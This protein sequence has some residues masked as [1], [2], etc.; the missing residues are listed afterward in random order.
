MN[1]SNKAQAPAKIDVLAIIDEV[2]RIVRHD[3]IDGPCTKEL[4]EAR[5]AIVELI[6]ASTAKPKD[7]VFP[8]IQAALLTTFG[9]SAR[10]IVDFD[11]FPLG[12]GGNWGD[13]KVGPAYAMT[14]DSG[15]LFVVAGG[16]VLFGFPTL[17]PAC[18]I[19]FCI[20]RDSQAHDS[21][22]WLRSQGKTE[23]QLQAETGKT[24]CPRMTLKLVATI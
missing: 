3:A 11:K 19:K 5:A 14:D 6:E 23:A 15:A 4:Q 22:V 8:G 7:P 21:W 20:V 10:R 9:E 17:E 24:Y 12:D 18:R 13:I 2:F 1:D 16:E